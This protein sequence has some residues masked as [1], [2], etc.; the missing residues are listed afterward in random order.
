[1]TEAQ[2]ALAPDK[3]ST[4]TVKEPFDSDPGADIILI[5]CDNAEFRARKAILSFI[6]PVFSDMFSLPHAITDEVGERPETINNLPFVHLSENGAVID[7]LLRYGYP[8]IN[9]LTIDS[10]LLIDVLNA[11]EKYDMKYAMSGIEAALTSMRH[12]KPEVLLFLYQRACNLHMEKEARQHA[13]DCLKLSQ[14][15][16]VK[17]WGANTS[18]G[19]LSNL[20]DYHQAVCM[21]A[22]TS[23]RNLHYPARD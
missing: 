13:F 18:V 19:A 7:T 1:M 15:S 5:S 16:I 9:P 10:Y 2:K 8:L 21:A 12:S 14:T 4:F 3:R 6:S 23:S 11:A 22:S 17:H 20:I